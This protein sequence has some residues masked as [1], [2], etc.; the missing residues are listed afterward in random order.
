MFLIHPKIKFRKALRVLSFSAA[1]A[2][3]LSIE[4]VLD[5]VRTLCCFRV[6]PV[7]LLI[8]LERIEYVLCRDYASAQYIIE[9]ES[10]NRFV[11][12]LGLPAQ[13]RATT[14]LR[15]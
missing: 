4:N 3:R 14:L 10:L 13:T 12:F 5:L 2:P 11:W 15:L 9:F 6:S 1:K 8:L 7:L